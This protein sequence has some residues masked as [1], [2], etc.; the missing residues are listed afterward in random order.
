MKY[1]CEINIFYLCI[2]QYPII[3]LGDNWL[4]GK[5]NFSWT[6]AGGWVENKF[7]E[8]SMKA[9]GENI[10][11]FEGTPRGKNWGSSSTLLRWLFLDSS[12]GL[13]GKE[14]PGLKWGGL[15]GIMKE[16]VISMARPRHNVDIWKTGRCLMFL[17]E[18]SFD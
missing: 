2:S 3:E 18:N 9:W 1:V 14:I 5:K 17:G 11:F 7:L 12:R 16:S 6:Q 4:M 15:R 13:G 10:L 8:S